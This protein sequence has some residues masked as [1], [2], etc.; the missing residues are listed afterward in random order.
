MSKKGGIDTA[1]GTP[2]ALG[3]AVGGILGKQLF[4][5]IRAATGKDGIVGA[6]QSALLLLLVAGTLIYTLKKS[7][8]QTKTIT[9]KLVCA[10]IGLALGFFSSF[11]GIGGGPF[12]LVVFHYFLSMDTKKAAANSLY[13][14]LF[15][16][17]SSLLLTLVR[18]S[19]P[20]F[21]L[22]MLIFMVIG[23]VGGGIVGKKLNARLSV[24]GVDKLFLGLLVL[25]ILICIF[26]VYRYLAM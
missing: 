14:I 5:M 10:V 15:S 23:G 9:S 21:E 16:Q 24:K 7:G 20:P 8:I 12:N 3:A 25:I 11:L 6:V 4:Q 2:L 19:V 22:G 17:A 1:T 13:V 18:G 26:N